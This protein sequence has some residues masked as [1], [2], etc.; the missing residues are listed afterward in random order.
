MWLQTSI[1]VLGGLPY[2]LGLFAILPG[3]VLSVILGAS[4][5]SLADS[6]SQTVNDN[7]SLVT[8]IVLVVGTVSTFLAVALASYYTKKSQTKLPPIAKQ[9]F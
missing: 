4:A 9:T 5:G 8:T 2:P 6:A 7:N 1:M 3:T